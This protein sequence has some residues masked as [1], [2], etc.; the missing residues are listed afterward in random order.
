[1]SN[2]IAVIGSGGWGTALALIADLAGN[3]VSLWV[4][5]P[6]KAEQLR[7]TRENKEYLPGVQ[8]PA[9]ITISDDLTSTIRGAMIVLFV[10][11]AQALREIM[12][13]A[14]P[15][16]DPHQII[17]C[18]SKG[19]ERSTQLLMSQVM[20]EV[21]ADPVFDRIGVLTGPNHA[22]EVGRQV[23]SATVISTLNRE[24]AR[25]AQKALISSHFRVYTNDDLIGVQVA[26]AMKNVIALAAGISDGLGFGDNTKAALLTRGLAEIARLGVALGANP[27]TFSGLAGMGDLIATCTSRHSRNAKAGRAL[28]EGKTLQE[29]LD[30]TNMVVEGV[31]TTQA[32]YQLADSLNVELPITRQVYAI[33]FEG[34][35]AREAVIDLMERDATREE[36]SYI[37]SSYLLRS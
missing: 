15:F 13:R 30:S 9:S 31:W 2:K 36:E 29:I 22:E 21:L 18:A 32:A 34:K 10:V 27:M 8:I 24:A 35:S 1:M 28:G 25:I 37:L 23:P 16:L 5:T 11:P 14:K 19:I 17:L 20:A 3:N 26:G 7:S 33:L 6:H 12:E 4:R